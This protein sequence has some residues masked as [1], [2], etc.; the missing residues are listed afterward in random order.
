[1]IR[2]KTKNKILLHTTLP[3]LWKNQPIL[4]SYVLFKRASPILW[5][6]CYTVFIL[7]CYKIMMQALKNKKYYYYYYIQLQKKIFLN[8]CMLRWVSMYFQICTHTF[9]ERVNNFFEKVN[10]QLLLKFSQQ[11]Q[12]YLNKFEII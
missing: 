10:K 1:M 11:Q 12:Q 8:L 3:P 4:L 6:S 9:F 2:K 7:K 5:H